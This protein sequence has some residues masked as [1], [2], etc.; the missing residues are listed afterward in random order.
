MSFHLLELPFILLPV[1]LTTAFWFWMLIDCRY[2][3]SLRGS[4]KVLWFLLILFT[5]LIGAIVYFIIG[6]SQKNVA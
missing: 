6:R 5:H 1:L 4:Q 2:N 3:P